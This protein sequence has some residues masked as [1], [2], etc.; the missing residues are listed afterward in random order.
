MLQSGKLG[1]GLLNIYLQVVCRMDTVLL[2]EVIVGNQLL[3]VLFRRP[4]IRRQQ[5]Y[6]GKL[7][8]DLNCRYDKI[9]HRIHQNGGSV[10]AVFNG[11]PQL[12]QLVLQRKFLRL[13]RR[14]VLQ[15]EQPI[16]VFG[17]LL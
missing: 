13:V 6:I 1:L 7:G 11:E 9:K 4:Q 10:I 17:V 3:Q 14:S 12:S 15:G 16:A 5:H 2:Q 8:Y